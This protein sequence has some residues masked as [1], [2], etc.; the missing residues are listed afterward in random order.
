MLSNL[1]TYPVPIC[2]SLVDFFSFSVLYCVDDVFP[3]HNLHP[4]SVFV[5][6]IGIMTIC[7]NYGK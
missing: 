6:Y 7:Y 5:S 2:S 3:I 1:N 4:C